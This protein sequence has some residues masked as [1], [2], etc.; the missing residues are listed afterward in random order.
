[1]GAYRFLERNH[2]LSTQAGLVKEWRD[3]DVVA[4]SQLVDFTGVERLRDARQSEGRPKPSYTACII[5]SIVRALKDHPKLNRLVY[6]GL[7]GYRWVQFEQIDIAV[8]TEVTEGDLDLAYASI[9]RNVDQLGVDGIAN[10]LVQVASAPSESPQLKRLKRFPAAVVSVLARGTGM[11]P[12]LW[13]QFRGG[14]C[15]ITS[16]AKYGVENIL[17]K[18]CWPLQFAFGKVKARPMVVDDRCIPR[19]SAMLSLSWH[20]ELTTGAVAARFFEQVV[21][22][23][24]ESIDL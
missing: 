24:E 18:S 22:Q 11:H 2:Y 4:F 19:Q 6:R 14:S 13:V 20:R 9:I 21:R 8:G 10:A 5:A 16:P 3:Q 1:M 7:S 15:A 12:K 17:V 23:L